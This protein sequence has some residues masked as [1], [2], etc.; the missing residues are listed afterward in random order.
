MDVGKIARRERAVGDLFESYFGDTKYSFIA[1]R[2]QGK[3]E[4]APTGN[5]GATSPKSGICENSA[6]VELLK[7]FAEEYLMLYKHY[8]NQRNSYAN[9]LLLAVAG[10]SV[11]P[12]AI[13]SSETHSALQSSLVAASFLAVLFLAVLGMFATRKFRFRMKTAYHRFGLIRRALDKLCPSADLERIAETGKALARKD[14][15]LN[16]DFEDKGMTRGLL[17][18]LLPWLLIVYAL[19]YGS[20]YF[21]LK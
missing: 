2:P 8:D 5:E 9:V 21:L 13:V 18:I 10:F 16:A 14:M 15:N 1:I 7:F 11:A 20:M 4:F 17:W 19:F 12:F 3:T 6:E